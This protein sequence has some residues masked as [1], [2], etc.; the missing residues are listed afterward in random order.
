MMISSEYLKRAR[1]LP[2]GKKI[3]AAQAL[4]ILAAM[5]AFVRTIPWLMSSEITEIHP[6]SD[7]SPPPPSWARAYSVH[8]GTYRYYAES[9]SDNPIRMW[10]S[11]GS[12]GLLIVPWMTLSGYVWFEGGRKLK[13]TEAGSGE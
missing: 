3:L 4:L 9:R 8:H 11:I 12:L 2:H 5:F 6:D 7:P 10:I 1:S 13:M